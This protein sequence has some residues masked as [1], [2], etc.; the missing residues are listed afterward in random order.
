MARSISALRR[1]VDSPEKTDVRVGL[2]VPWEPVEEGG[3][4]NGFS[5]C[6]F[7]SRR[8]RDLNRPDDEPAS[9][10][11]VVAAVVGG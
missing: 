2:T 5:R 10:V 1:R 4:W 6:A 9:I 11:V 8:Y 3:E 7:I